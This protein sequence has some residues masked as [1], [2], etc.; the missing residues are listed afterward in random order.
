MPTSLPPPR[1]AACAPVRRAHPGP[2]RLLLLRAALVLGALGV[3]G[4]ADGPPLTVPADRLGDPVAQLVFMAVLEG[5]LRDG[6]ANE[7]IDLI[8]PR[9]PDTGGA[10]LEELFVWSCPLCMPV[11][12]ALRMYRERG[13]FLSDKAGRDRFGAGLAEGVRRRLREGPRAARAAVLEE[14]VAGWVRRRF[15][16]MR[17]ADDERIEPVRRRRR[18]PR[19]GRAAAQGACAPAT[20]ATTT[21]PSMAPGRSAARHARRSARPAAA[22][23]RFP[24]RADPAGGGGGRGAA[25]RPGAGRAAC[26]KCWSY[27]SPRQTLP[28]HDRGTVP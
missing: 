16:L 17:L 14:L 28:G 15:A 8:L 11:V 19:A 13:R 27:P 25:G 26:T 9:N 10:R 4:A 3:L 2:A 5:C 18:P 1:C 23:C 21:A 6:V 7:D 12:D 20:T 24:P 22:R